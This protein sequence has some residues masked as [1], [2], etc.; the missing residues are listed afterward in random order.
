MAYIVNE[1]G[2]IVFTNGYSGGVITDPKRLAEIREQ[3]LSHETVAYRAEK[4][5][6]P[7]NI[8]KT[9]RSNRS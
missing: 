6:A 2:T 7:G 5:M 9:Q 1:D 8:F 3:I 4:G